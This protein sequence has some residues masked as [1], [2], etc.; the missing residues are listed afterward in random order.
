MSCGGALACRAWSPAH[1]ARRRPRGALL[2]KSVDCHVTLWQPEEGPYAADGQV[3]V[4]A[5][6]ELVD[7]D[8]WFLRF[9]LCARGRVLACGNR[10]GVVR[11]WDMQQP[12]PQL[13]AQLHA[14]VPAPA[15]HKAAAK[16]GGA[17]VKPALPVRQA[18]PSADG[19]IVIACCED[20]TIWRWDRRPA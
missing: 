11:V 2:T 10:C 3:R 16:A 8:L 1:T 20:G 15:S 13:L 7:A 4:L 18:M 17:R 19:R 12:A 6:A 9:A 14:R 5:H